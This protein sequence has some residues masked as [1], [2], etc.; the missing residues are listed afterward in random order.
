MAG[1]FFACEGLGFVCVWEPA[2]PAMGVEATW[3][4]PLKRLP[5]KGPHRK[6]AAYCALWP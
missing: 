2:M 4:S 1:F 6:Q 3:L 5:Q